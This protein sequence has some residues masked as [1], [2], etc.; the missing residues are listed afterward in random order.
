MTRRPAPRG[1]RD[2]T[3][4]Q[5][6]ELMVG[7][8]ELVAPRRRGRRR[9]PRS[10]AL[11]AVLVVVAIVVLLVPRLLDG[12][13]GAWPGGGTGPGG[14]AVPAE[15][16]DGA[17]RATV[18]RVVDGDTVVVDLDGESDRLRLIG[19][20]TPETVAPGRPVDCF[21]P[22]ASAWTTEALPAGATVWLEAD[23][24]Q[25]DRDKYDRLLRFV[26][27]DAG[28]LV[29]RELVELGYAREDTYDEPYR[30]RDEFVALEEAAEAEGAGL[31][32]RC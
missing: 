4:R 29:N 19:V 30:Y 18:E 1:G 17:E 11:V 21:G 15:V 16:P 25:G 8:D 26:W 31:W 12:T 27:T 3:L 9:P 7:L 5:A 2:D 22:E 10:V 13:G 6:R 14:A 24:T 28:A 20:D 32:G 23:P